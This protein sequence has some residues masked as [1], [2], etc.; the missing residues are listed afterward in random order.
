MY[1]RQL[2]VPGHG[3]PAAS[4]PA[5][6]SVGVAF[7]LTFFFGPLGV[8]YVQVGPALILTL[9]ALIVGFATVGL[10]LPL[11]W[12]ISIVF[13]CVRA[14]QKRTAFQAWLATDR[15]HVRAPMLGPSPPPVASGPPPGWYP[16]PQGTQSL[17][18]WDGWRWTT[19]VAPR[20]HLPPSLRLYHLFREA[21]LAL[22][23]VPGALGVQGIGAMK[24]R[25][26]RGSR[27]LLP[28]RRWG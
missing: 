11:V 24:E 25:L 21:D 23:S 28:G 3:Y 1:N 14:S 4:P 13:A 15:G 8:F 19:N 26:R 5:D 12:L 27:G 22:G 10:A 20:P 7:L 16:D 18:W 6:K 2:P 9:L 17:R